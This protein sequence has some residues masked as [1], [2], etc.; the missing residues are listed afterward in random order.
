MLSVLAL[1]LVVAAAQ[2]VTH[3]ERVSAFQSCL[4]DADESIMDC[5]VSEVT[6]APVQVTVAGQKRLYDAGVLFT[7][8]ETRGDTDPFT[9]TPITSDMIKFDSETQFSA[10]GYV[11][12]CDPPHNQELMEPELARK[13]PFYTC[14]ITGEFIR[15]TEL[16]TPFGSSPT[17]YPL[18]SKAGILGVSPSTFYF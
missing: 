9:R 17:M 6:F 1:A 5:L 13:F 4:S 8:F 10:I 2:P 14:P 3:S 7:H 12:E 16:I 18:F 11:M 15:P